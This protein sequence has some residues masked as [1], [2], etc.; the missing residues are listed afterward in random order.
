VTVPDANGDESKRVVREFVDA[1]NAQ[2]WAKLRV[3]VPAD[4]VRHSAAAGSAEIRSRDDLIRFLQDE[5]RTF[6]D[7][8]EEIVEMM[9][10]GE[11]MAVRHRF[12][13]TQRG[14]LGPYPP[15][16]KVMDVEYIAIY[17]VRG[18]QIVE[19]WAEWDNLAG[20][21]QLGHI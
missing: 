19:A 15:T 5:Y 13:G 21:K 20:L 11:R 6:P 8:H 14:A 1:V 7:A 12:R 10:D 9:I 2:D 16:G 3:L 18:N 17:V 4:F